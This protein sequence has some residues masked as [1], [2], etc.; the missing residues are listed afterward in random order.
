MNYLKQLKDI[1]ATFLTK[2]IDYQQLREACQQY[3]A[4]LI[5]L[6]AID[7]EEETNREDI[8]FEYGKAIGTTWA[9]ACVDDI[10][11]TRNFIRGVFQAVYQLQAERSEPIQILYAGTGPFATLILPLF[12]AFSPAEIQVIFLEVNPNSVACLRRVLQKLEAEAYVQ[13]IIQADATTLQLDADLQPDLV[14]SE[15]MLHALIKEQQVPIMLNIV[16]QIPPHAL[17]IPSNIQLDLAWVNLTAPTLSEKFQAITKLLHFDKTSMQ[18]YIAT[19]REVNDYS[20]AISTPLAAPK[21]ADFSQL[22]ILTTIHIFGEEW[23]Q[24]NESSLTIPYI[25]MD[26]HQQKIP[27]TLELSYR[28]QPSPDWRISN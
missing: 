8:H 12:T 5:E 25:I 17:L 28:L 3:K 23:L 6:S 7:L 21:S 4:L 11:R 13:K 10:M 27:A 14:L 18:N 26:A 20:L 15:T 16:P 9:A 1:T 24:M 22:A 19:K 2:Q